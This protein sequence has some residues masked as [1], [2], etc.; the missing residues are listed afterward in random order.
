M[1][2]KKEVGNMN[3]TDVQ[4]TLKSFFEKNS[5]S[6]LFMQVSGIV[7]ILYPIY[8]ILTRFSCFNIITGII[9]WVSILFYF[10]YI[11][12]LIMCIAKNDFVSISIAFG[13]NVILGIVDICVFSFSISYIISIIA[14]IILTFAALN[15][16]NKFD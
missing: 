7:A 6:F 9:S 10:A 13:L 8:I 15:C 14:Y 12:G 1:L 3:F 16:V 5:F 4:R 11:L 2:Y